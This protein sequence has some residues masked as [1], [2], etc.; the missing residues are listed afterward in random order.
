MI[1]VSMYFGNLVA[2]SIFFF[3]C[4]SFV[5]HMHGKFFIHYIIFFRF[6]CIFFYWGRMGY[7]GNAQDS[8]TPGSA[9]ESL[10]DHV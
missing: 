1:K 8:V 2:F 5:C 4:F 3:C 7:I 9:P 10:K 6:Q